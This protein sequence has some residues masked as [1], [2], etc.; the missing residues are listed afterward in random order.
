MAP[1]PLPLPAPVPPA[2]HSRLGAAGRQGGWERWRESK[3]VREVREGCGSEELPLP[4]GRA[5]TWPCLPKGSGLSSREEPALA[6]G[7]E[8]LHVVPTS[9]QAPCNAA[10]TA[11]AAVCRGR[12]LGT[13][14]PPGCCP[15]LGASGWCLRAT[16]SLQE[17]YTSARRGGQCW[18]QQGE[19]TH[20]GPFAMVQTLWWGRALRGSTPPTAQHC[21]PKSDCTREWRKHRGKQRAADVRP[22]VRA[23]PEPL[24][25]C[26][27][28]GDP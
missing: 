1:Q 11:P 23:S 9:A 28:P 5:K 22:P 3:Q 8:R 20:P 2:A 15:C 25:L 10:G 12:G 13:P 14:Q 19:I 26:A 21:A 7:R 17:R 6:A 24:H 18:E 4:Q 16:G 27:A